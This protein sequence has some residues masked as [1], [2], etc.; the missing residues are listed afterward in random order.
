MDFT[1]IFIEYFPVDTVSQ[2]IIKL[3]IKGLNTNVSLNS[4]YKLNKQSMYINKHNYISG[5]CLFIQSTLTTPENTSAKLTDRHTQVRLAVT[6]FLRFLM[7]KPSRCRQREASDASI[8]SFTDVP[9]KDSDRYPLKMPLSC[10]HKTS[11]NGAI[12]LFTFD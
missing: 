10:G 12:N 11:L 1:G 8:T 9:G 5:I 7:Y 6:S 3:A 2:E 4:F